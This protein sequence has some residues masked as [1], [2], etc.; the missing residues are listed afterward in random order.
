VH[1]FKRITVWY[2]DDLG[3]SHSLI[4]SIFAQQEDKSKLSH[5]FVIQQSFYATPVSS[6]IEYVKS[7]V[8]LLLEKEDKVI[9]FTNDYDYIR[10][11][12][13]FTPPDKFGI[14]QADSN[15]F[16]DTFV[17]LKPNPSLELGE[18]LYRCSVKRAL[19]GS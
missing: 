2:Q 13:E 10:L 3:N 12:E 9:V 14:Y 15:L 1:K 16:V 4:N 18:F 8:E 11:L 19:K 5:A 6:R 17:D 7:Q